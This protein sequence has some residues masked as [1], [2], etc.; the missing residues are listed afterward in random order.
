MDASLLNGY[1]KT[2]SAYASRYFG[3]C[4]IKTNEKMKDLRVIKIEHALTYTVLIV[5]RNNKN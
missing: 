2:Y 5:T 4:H 3:R 1:A